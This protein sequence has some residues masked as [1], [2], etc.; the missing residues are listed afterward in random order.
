VL[1]EDFVTAQVPIKQK[2]ISKPEPLDPVAEANA[3]NDPG[4]VLDED[5]SLH[6]RFTPVKDRVEDIDTGEVHHYHTKEV[7]RCDDPIKEDYNEVDVE[8]IPKVKH[9]NE[10]VDEVIDHVEGAPKDMH[11]L[12]CKPVAK[13]D[14][15]AEEKEQPEMDTVNLK[16]HICEEDLK[17]D[18]VDC[19]KESSHGGNYNCHN[20][21]HNIPA[22]DSVDENEEY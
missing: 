5:T 9:H 18:E 13:E 3:E 10:V 4:V 16:H 11:E 19:G 12:H 20:S 2:S 8:R 6:P 14:T 7:T 1:N 21:N 15:I 22:Y 17:V